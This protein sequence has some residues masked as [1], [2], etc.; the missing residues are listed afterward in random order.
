[1]DDLQWLTIMHGLRSMPACMS[2]ACSQSA[3]SVTARIAVNLVAYSGVWVWI[4][5]FHGR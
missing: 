3:G 1:V 5:Q 2:G 4:E